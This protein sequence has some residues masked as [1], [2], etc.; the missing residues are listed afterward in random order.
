[1]QAY[2]AACT[3]SQS[4]GALLICV[5]GGRLSEGINFSDKLARA[6]IIVGMP[7]PNPQCPLLREKMAYLDRQFSRIGASCSG[8]S[9]GRL[10]YDG[11]C[12]RLI[13]QAIGRAVRHANDYAAVVLLDRRFSRSSVQQKLPSWV[14]ESLRNTIGLGNS[15]ISIESTLNHLNLFFSRLEN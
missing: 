5:I 1:M 8:S 11:L 9:P 15:S 4:N 2:G 14:R 12:M 7:Y 6:V 10:H 13:N 3:E